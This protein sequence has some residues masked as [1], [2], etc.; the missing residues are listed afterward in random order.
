MKRLSFTAL[1]IITCCISYAQQQ[2][3]LQAGDTRFLDSIR[4]QYNAAV[5]G[6]KADLVIAG[7]NDQ[8]RLMPE[9]QK[10]IRGKSNAATYYKAFFER[11]RIAQYKRQQYKI[12][13]LDSVIIETGK[14]TMDL[15]NKSTSLHTELEGKYLSVWRRSPTGNLSLIT[16]AWNYNRPVENTE[17][18]RFEKVP[19]VDI[20]L[21]PHLP[22][23]DNI[24]FEL[25]AYNALME[26]TITH[27]DAKGWSQFFADDGMFIYSFN[28]AYEGRS[29]LDAFLEKH[30]KEMPV[31]ENLAI[32]NDEIIDLG[33]GYIIEYASHIAVWRNGTASGVN[34]GKDL[35][36]WRREPN[37]TLKMFVQIAMYD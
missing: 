5:I 20:A 15:T 2:N 6:N 37:G 26:N 13:N 14:F 8:V 30:A 4:A 12:L 27:K 9:F 22:V 3:E 28:P 1:F 29:A 32:R 17:Q 21:Q 34:S 31:F 7:Y 23:T 18:F 25:A 33:N 19:T 10:T 36:V 11:F 16:E 24:S 35:R